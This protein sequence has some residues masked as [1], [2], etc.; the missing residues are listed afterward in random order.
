MADIYTLIC[1]YLGGTYIAQVSSNSPGEAVSSWLGTHSA[2]QH[3]PDTARL[4]VKA[5]LAD[6]SPVPLDG[7]SNVWCFSTP[8]KQGLI[9]IHLVLTR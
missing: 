8:A 2:Q 6:D 5:T 4:A 1:E 3:I 7:C 9:L